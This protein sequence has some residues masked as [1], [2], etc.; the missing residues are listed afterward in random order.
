MVKMNLKLIL[1]NIVYRKFGYKFT[2]MQ[3]LFVNLDL[4]IIV[5]Y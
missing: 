1:I 4:F 2:T 3:F 5:Y